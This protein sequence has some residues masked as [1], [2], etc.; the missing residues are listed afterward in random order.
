MN[1]NNLNNNNYNIS[2]LAHILRTMYDEGVKN[3][4]GV[5]AIHIFGIKYGKFYYRKQLFNN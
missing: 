1:T 5:G 2:T 3:R 4:L